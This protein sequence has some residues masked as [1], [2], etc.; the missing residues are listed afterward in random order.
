MTRYVGVENEQC[1]VNVDIDV[2]IFDDDQ[3]AKHWN[4]EQCFVTWSP[5][6]KIWI[7]SRAEGFGHPFWL[8]P[9]LFLVLS[10]YFLFYTQDVFGWDFINLLSGYMVHYIIEYSIRVY[11][12]FSAKSIVH[13][14][15]IFNENVA[16]D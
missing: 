12:S 5:L 11:Q 14:S 13:I 1:V 16:N 6:S 4:K 9:G 8:Q 15:L 2:V 3:A 7:P 10:C